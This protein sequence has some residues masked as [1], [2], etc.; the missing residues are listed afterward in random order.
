LE[1]QIPDTG[2]SLMKRM[3]SFI[4]TDRKGFLEIVFQRRGEWIL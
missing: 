4:A 2:Y 3:Y 1:E